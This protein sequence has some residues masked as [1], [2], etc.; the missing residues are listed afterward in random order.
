MIYY[1]VLDT[2]VI[3]ASLLSKHD[4]SAAVQVMFKIISGEVIVVYSNS[5]IDEYRNVL[6]RSKFNFDGELVDKL[7]LAIQ[8]FGILVEPSPS[9]EILP[10]MKD[11]P[12]YEVVLEIKDEGGHLIT[13]NLKHFPNKPYVVT[14]AQFLEII[15]ENK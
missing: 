5:I 3:V 9:G 13:G 7:I 2:N 14:A 12:F 15:K 11:L 6:H 1:A 4:D 8:Q 10:D